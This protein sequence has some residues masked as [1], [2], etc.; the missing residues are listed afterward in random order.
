MIAI[1]NF[2][3]PILF[4]VFNR[5][6]TTRKVFEVIRQVKPRYLYIAAD[7]PR[8][9]NQNDE[10]NCKAVKQLFKNIDWDCELH[11]LY[12]DQNLGCRNAVSSAITWFFDNVEE[13]IVLEDDILP[14]L[15]FFPYC[16]QLLEY[17]RHDERVMH[18][19]G[20]NVC[21]KWKEKKQSYHGS[22][23]G[24][25]W[26]W[27]SWRR[28]WQRYDVDIKQWEDQQL[29]ENV[30]KTYFPPE[31]REQRKALYN[32][33]YQGKIN[34]WDYQWTL[35]RLING[36]LCVIPSVNLTENIGFG[37]GSTHTAT[38]PDWAKQKSYKITLPLNTKTVLKQDKD[39]DKVHLNLSSDKQNASLNGLV[40][41]LLR[42]LVG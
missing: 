34:T 24:G 18:I 39:Y 42:K 13:G 23:F 26:G 36:G 14:D 6:D 31:L 15:S 27:A 11:T 40:K 8:P 22:Y 33:L 9:G 21:G 20:F 41:K 32:D 17:Y 35:A 3:T 4:L 7:G 38:A 12:R 16:Q 28:A 1:N 30:L 29:Q 25:I 2:N 19:A 10:E 37:E 5:P